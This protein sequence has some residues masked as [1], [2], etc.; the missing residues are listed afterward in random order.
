MAIKIQSTADFSAGNGYKMVVYGDAGIGKTSLIKT[1]E[2]SLILSAEKGLLSLKKFDFPYI[3]IGS[4]KKIDEAYEWLKK[5]K[6]FATVFLDTVSEVSE[7][8]LSDFLI[9]GN[10]IIKGPLKDARQGYRM[11]GE[12]MMPMI[13]KFRDIPGKNVVF[14]AKMEVK[15]D[16]DSGILHHRPMIPGNVV[17]NQLPYMFD[18]V[19]FYTQVRDKVKKE[20]VRVF[21]TGKSTGIIAKD[22]SG[23]LDFHE[24]PE[25]DYIIS[26]ALGA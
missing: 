1:A 21:Q 8:L 26:K 2:Q 23:N 15:E 3:E 16:E 11:M 4:P 13:R 9:N 10:D 22:R 7:V 19:F 18:G 5:D 6:E 14:L 20:D 12:A 25:I 17:K 24:R